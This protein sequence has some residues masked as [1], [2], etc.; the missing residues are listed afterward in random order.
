MPSVDHEAIVDL[1]RSRPRLAAELMTEALGLDLPAHTEQ[2][3][4]EADFTE[5]TP[6]PYQADLAVVLRDESGP[7]YGI[8]VEVQLGRD[9]DKPFTW[10]Y[11]AAALRLRL[12]CP[13][14]VLVVT[15]DESLRRWAA[16]P[17][18]AGHGIRFE[19]IVIGPADVPV[20]TDIDEAIERP[21]LSV[22]S[23]MA[24]GREEAGELIAIAAV[25]GLGRL[26]AERATFYYDLVLSSLGEAARVA[27][28]DLMQSRR[29]EYR[30]DF[31]RKYFSQ[32]REEGLDEGLE[33]G[34]EEGREEG[35]ATG[36]ALAVV[37]ILQ[38]RRIAISPE[39]RARILA[40]TDE[41]KLT[42]WIACALHI[43]S[44]DTLLD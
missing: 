14:C 40:C 21:E 24:H 35:R 25:A 27:L 26:D 8:V 2:D 11:Y 17:I 31:A 9:A 29:Y 10:P 5:I 38:M 12:R 13:T 3:I 33:K 22:L 39:Q 16:R 7:R 28:E 43:D 6:V 41:A 37:D 1:F 20:V 30:S 42:E 44:A 19:P 36:K 15:A 34:R 32:G 18:D 4:T 23:A